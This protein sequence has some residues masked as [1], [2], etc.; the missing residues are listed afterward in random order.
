MD[1]SFRD[2]AYRVIYNSD[3]RIPPTDEML[4]DAVEKI[5]SLQGDVTSL[6]AM[7]EQVEPPQHDTDRCGTNDCSACEFRALATDF[8][9]PP[10]LDEFCPESSQTD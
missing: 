4:E 10:W 5:R 8:G 7:L 1:T 9:W 3:L 6:K 2:D